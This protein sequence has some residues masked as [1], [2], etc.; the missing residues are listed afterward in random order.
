MN[1]I[2]KTA[3]LVLSTLL[4]AASSQAASFTSVPLPTLNSDLHVWTSGAIYD[5]IFPGTQS[6]SG[7][8]FTL[9]SDEA[10]RDVFVGKGALELDV[11]LY[12]VDAG[13]THD[14]YLH[15]LIKSR[16]VEWL[17]ARF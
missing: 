2:I 14:R 8:P 11:N 3:S 5:S 13:P 7:V 10:G 4:F 17:Q 16:S 12:G 1:L 15:K 6:F 9:Q